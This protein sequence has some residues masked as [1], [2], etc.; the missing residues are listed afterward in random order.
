MW[1]LGL[2]DWE[3]K[4]RGD[5]VNTA[6]GDWGNRARRDLGIMDGTLLILLAEYEQFN[7]TTNPL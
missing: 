4:A 3:N 1:R 6:R 7:I 5:W 2:N